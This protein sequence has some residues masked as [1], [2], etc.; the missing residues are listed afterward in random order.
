MDDDDEL[1]RQLVERG[2]A[3]TSIMANQIETAINAAKSSHHAYAEMPVP[4]VCW[5]L[6]YLSLELMLAERSFQPYIDRSSRASFI[7]SAIRYLRDSAALNGPTQP[8]LAE[9]ALLTVDSFI[10]DLINRRAYR[11]F[12]AEDLTYAG[13]IP[14]PAGMPT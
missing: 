12:G 14:A 13:L 11:P 3:A 10:D 4:I 2:V 1:K 8:D 6:G 7:A 5:Y 9:Q